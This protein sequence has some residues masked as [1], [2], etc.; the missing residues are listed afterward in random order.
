MKLHKVLTVDGTVYPVVKDDVRL[1]IRSPGRA[2]FT[3]QAQAPLRGLVMLDI[4][5]NEATLQR[6][7]IGYVE[8]STAANGQQQIL[9]CRELAA[10]LGAPLPL[11]LRHVHLQA[12]LEQV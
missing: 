4:G 7:F 12:V 9:F 3:V 6:F 11:D 1:E 8:R 2:S 5:Y 10:I